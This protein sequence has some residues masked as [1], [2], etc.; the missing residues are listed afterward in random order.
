MPT[1]HHDLFQQATKPR[2][3]FDQ[4]VHLIDRMFSAM[5]AF[6]CRYTRLLGNMNADFGLTR[7]RLRILDAVIRL[8]ANWNISDIA[9]HLDLSRQTVHRTMRAMETAG[10]I[11][12]E[13]VGKKALVPRLAS[14]GRIV[15]T[16]RL[17]QAHEWSHKLAWAIPT[18]AASKAAW[19]A[20]RLTSNLPPRMVT[21]EIDPENLPT[22]MPRGYSIEYNGRPRNSW[23]VP[24]H[25]IIANGDPLWPDD[26]RP[27]RLRAGGRGYGARATAAR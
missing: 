14:T 16:L 2:Y 4:R 15:A 26:L 19:I 22:G 18:A 17:T 3:T 20:E 1:T 8:P 21:D 9:R 5:K 12:L 7:A 6:D 11:T 27:A 25:P 13:P 24:K 23:L 10:L